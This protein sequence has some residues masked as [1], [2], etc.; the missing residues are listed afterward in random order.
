MSTPVGE[1]GA[2]YLAVHAGPGAVVTGA[3]TACLLIGAPALQLRARSC[4]V[5]VLA[6]DRARWRGVPRSAEAA[7]ASTLGDLSPFRAI[8]ADTAK[9]VD[10][11]ELA[12]A[13]ARIKHLEA[14]WDDAEPPLKPQGRGRLAYGRQRDRPRVRGTVRRQA[15]SRK[16]QAV[17]RKP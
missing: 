2:D 3:L 17:S 1:A 12:G 14:S 10:K 6:G 4:A 5:A 16:P 11:G 8:A 13:K 9:L 15:V 7:A